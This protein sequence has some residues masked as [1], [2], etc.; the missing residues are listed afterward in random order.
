MSGQYPAETFP[1]PGMVLMKPTCGMQ[2]SSTTPSWTYRTT[3]LRMGGVKVVMP[4]GT[5]IPPIHA[6][7]D[8]RKLGSSVKS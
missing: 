1:S 2:T 6:L 5:V 7:H 4:C 3:G 8:P